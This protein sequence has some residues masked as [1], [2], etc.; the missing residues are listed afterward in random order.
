MSP[1]GGAGAPVVTDEMIEAGISVLW[2]SGVVEGQLDSDKSL[3]SEIYR[4]MARAALSSDH[5]CGE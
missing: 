4:A 2:V 3:V 1:D 5:Q